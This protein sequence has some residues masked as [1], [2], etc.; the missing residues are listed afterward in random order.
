MIRTIVP[1]TLFAILVVFFWTGL[2]LNPTEIP[3]PLIGK[4]APQFDLPG[5]RDPDVRLT[6]EQL[7]GGVSLLNVWATWCAGCRQEHDF[8]L[9]LA[10]SGVPIYG[11]NYKDDR[12][13]AIAWLEQLGDPYLASGFDGEGTVAIDWGVYG[14]PETFLIDA[15]GVVR[16][17]HIG[18][19]D[20]EVWRTKLLP[21]IRLLSGESG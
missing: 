16:Y 11:L 13:Q 1:A 2:K 4:P 8:L 14:A 12:D 3:S 21:R 19:L 15:G 20:N 7:Q 9:Q 10:Q 6:T 5:L 18:P 17:K